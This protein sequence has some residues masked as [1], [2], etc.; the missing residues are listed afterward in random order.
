MRAQRSMNPRAQQGMILLVGMI[1]LIL[2]TLM[3][4]AAL[5][6]GS[7]NFAVVANQQT[8]LEATRTAEQVIEQVMNN[9]EI[10]LV[11]TTGT[12]GNTNLFGTG[13]NTV[14]VD[15]NG[16]ASADYTVEVS[17][18]FCVKRQIIA[19]ATL[20]FADSDDLGCAR[21][22]DQASLGVEGAGSSDSL[23]SQVTWDVTARAYDVF[24]QADVRITQ[25]IGQRV[26]TTRVATV[27][28]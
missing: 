12:G 26:A 24:R 16:D 8:R 20:N 9:T 25:G 13:N 2:L 10:I 19:Q 17:Q 27:C 1:M 15:I 7:A 11:N 21:S 22:V 28:D 14:T 4:V 3:A 5:R 6:F 18:P 23:C